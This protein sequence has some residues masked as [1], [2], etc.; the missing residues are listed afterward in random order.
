[1]LDELPDATSGYAT[2]KRFFALDTR[3]RATSPSENYRSVEVS[4][5]GPIDKYEIDLVGS[6]ERVRMSPAKTASRSSTIV[7][8]C[9][10]RRQ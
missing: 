9:W 3:S 6:S 2:V 5:L 10:R 8:L 7:L 4:E 1:M